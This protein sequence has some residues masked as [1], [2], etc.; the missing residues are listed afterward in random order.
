MILDVVKRSLNSPRVLIPV[1]QLL[2]DASGSRLPDVDA[3]KLTQA[4]AQRVVNACPTSALSLGNSQLALNYGE[5][6]GCGNCLEA[7]EGAFVAA[8]KL[9]VC[10]GSNAALVRRW[11]IKTATEIMIDEPGMAETAKSIRAIVG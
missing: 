3:S 4:I 11:N 1:E 7:G 10:G 6:T 5:C 8:T 2:R 9:R